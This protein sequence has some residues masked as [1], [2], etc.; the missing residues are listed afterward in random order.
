M[1]KKTPPI[2]WLGVGLCLLLIFGDTSGCP[3][4]GPGT[5]APYVV[6]VEIPLTAAIAFPGTPEGIMQMDKDYPGVLAAVEQYVKSK[7]NAQYRTVDTTNTTPPSM[8]APWV[9]EAWKLIDKSGTPAI[10]AAT[11]TAGFP[12]TPLPKLPADALKLL[13]SLGK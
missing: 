3:I 11:P 5:K 1:K 9:Q 4:T 6:P 10:I 2:V 13:T 7:P 12:S 8:D